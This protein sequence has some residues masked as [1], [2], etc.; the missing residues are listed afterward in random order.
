MFYLVSETN[1]MDCEDK[2]GEVPANPLKAQLYG[3]KSFKENPG[4]SLSAVPGPWQLLSG[5]KL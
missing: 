5:S 3:S 4:T 2:P 1:S